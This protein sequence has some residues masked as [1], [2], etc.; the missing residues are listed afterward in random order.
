MLQFLDTDGEPLSTER[1]RG[2]PGVPGQPMPVQFECRSGYYLWADPAVGVTA[3]ARLSGDTVWINIADS[4]IDLTPYA[5]DITD[6]ELRVTPSAAGVT[7]SD[8]VVSETPA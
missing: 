4:P 5:P 7:D 1:I 3:E 6:F 8:F 2:V